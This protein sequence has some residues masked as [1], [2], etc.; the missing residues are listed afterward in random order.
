MCYDCEFE[1]ALYGLGERFEL[2]KEG[3]KI[4]GECL[5]GTFFCLDVEVLGCKPTNWICHIRIIT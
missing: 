4:L 1:G 3:P 2:M 5:D